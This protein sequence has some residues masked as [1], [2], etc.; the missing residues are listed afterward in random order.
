IFVRDGGG[1][2]RL[3]GALVK[4]I[5][6]S[7]GGAAASRCAL[8]ITGFTA[9]AKQNKIVRND[10][11]LI[12]LLAGFFVVPRRS[13]QPPFDIN[14]VTFLHVLAH[15][16]RQPLPG[17][18]V[19]PFGAILPFAGLIFVALVGGQRKFGDCRAAGSK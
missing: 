6:G 16:L 9:A 8:R 10:L 13:L 11:S 14:L 19:V 3:G 18:N 17:H 4:V 7:S 5:A 15:N 2:L 1:M 12:F